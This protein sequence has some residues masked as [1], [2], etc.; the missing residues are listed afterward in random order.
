[1]RLQYNLENTVQNVAKNIDKMNKK[2]VILCD[3]GMLDGK[4]YA[5]D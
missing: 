1:M 5:G 4:A 3:R 2:S